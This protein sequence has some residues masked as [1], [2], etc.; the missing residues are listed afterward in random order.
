[1][2]HPF[3]INPFA[4]GGATDPFISCV[5]FLAHFDTNS[6][7]GSPSAGGTTPNSIYPTHGDPHLILLNVADISNNDYKFGPG[8]LRRDGGLVGS[9]SASST[10]VNTDY[11]TLTADFTIEFWFRLDTLPT[12][13]AIL[14][15]LR[16]TGSGNCP[17]IYMTASGV[18]KYFATSDR[19]TSAA[20]T[21][22]A[23]VWTHVAYCRVGVGSPTVYTGRLFVNGTSVGSWTDNLN[24]NN[25][26]KILIGSNNANILHISY[27]EFRFSNG[28]FG[29]G[30]ARYTANFTP[31][32]A[33]FPNS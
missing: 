5:V 14:F 22:T 4:F 15:D 12:G 26:S 25:N 10:S 8:A 2:T 17:V 30:A 7:T 1:M 32:T 28:V 24:Y 3:I 9:A 11:Q 27:D 23:G 33:P 20:G 6:I 31:Q 13:T 16:P 21:I 19:I 29:A 18:I